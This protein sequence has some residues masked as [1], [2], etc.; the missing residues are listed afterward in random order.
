MI[1]LND[2]S[3]LTVI[4]YDRG[5]MGEFYSHLL[6]L[7]KFN[8]SES[9]SYNNM[10]KTYKT[11]KTFDGLIYTPMQNSYST[12]F[13]ENLY[14]KSIHHMIIDNEYNEAREALLSLINLSYFIER[15]EFDDAVSNNKFNELKK[16]M[17]T[18]ECYDDVI[19][20]YHNYNMIDITEIFTNC[21]HINFY[22][23]PNKRWIF[24]LLY[25]YKK[26]I[27]KIYEG[28]EWLI[29][30][31]KKLINFFNFVICSSNSIPLNNAINIDA[32]DLLNVKN[33][34]NDI[35]YKNE[36]TKLLVN[37]NIKAN[38]DIITSLG[39]DINDDEV[40]IEKTILNLYRR[41][42]K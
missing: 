5:Q 37:N 31:E 2:F 38:I 27:N 21:T 40:D 29:N 3:G 36:E 39:Y 23:K 33:K 24:I 1:S 13:N 34:I 12:I 32:F 20:K 30:S 16:L 18:D 6:H 8:K 14:G 11:E 19:S 7:K 41:F 42:L 10:W 35:F 4:S 26:L 28:S 9:T 22:C 15:N 25:F 17:H